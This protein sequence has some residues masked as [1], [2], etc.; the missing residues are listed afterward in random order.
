M[1]QI[2]FIIT[3][4]TTVSAAAAFRTLLD[5]VARDLPAVPGCHG[6]EI[7]RATDD[8]CTF[9]LIERWESIESHKA[10]ISRLVESGAWNGIAAHLAQAPQSQ[11][12]HRLEA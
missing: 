3:F 8:D 4:K 9:T 7:F 12:F 10:H 11:Y 5:G 2:R 6:V 1:S